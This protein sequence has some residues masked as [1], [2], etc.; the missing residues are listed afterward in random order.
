MR[1]GP[2]AGDL[3]DYTQVGS[4]SKMKNYFSPQPPPNLEPVGEILIREHYGKLTTV[5]CSGQSRT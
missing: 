2:Q 4:R 5:V 3:F 1:C